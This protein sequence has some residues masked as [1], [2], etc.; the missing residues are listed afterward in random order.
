VI[1][2]SIKSH[3]ADLQAAE[4]ARQARLA[5]ARE[6]ERKINNNGSIGAFRGGEHKRVK[7]GE[8]VEKSGN[9]GKGD[10]EFLPEDKEGTG[11]EEG[12]YLSKEVREL[13]AK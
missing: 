2:H 4:D 11:N 3:L 9:S 5:A 6:R 13:M 10:E 1:E 12:P 7:L 8:G